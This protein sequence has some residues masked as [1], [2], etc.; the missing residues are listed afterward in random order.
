MNTDGI[1][2]VFLRLGFC[3]PVDPLLR[4]HTAAT[5]EAKKAILWP[6]V[7]PIM[8]RGI[9]VQPGLLFYTKY[10]SSDGPIKWCSVLRMGRNINVELGK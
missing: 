9:S 1:D 8:A 10:E 5:L 4:G 7:A 6:V 2:C 3:P